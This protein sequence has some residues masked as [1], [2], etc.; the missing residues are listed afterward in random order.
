MEITEITVIGAVGTTAGTSHQAGHRHQGT[1]QDI[2]QGID[3]II[4]TTTI[5]D[6]D[7]TT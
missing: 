6:Y 1:K 2:K 3:I 7:Y 5:G 4:I